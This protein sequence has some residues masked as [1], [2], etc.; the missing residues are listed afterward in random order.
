MVQCPRDAVKGKRSKISLQWSS[1]NWVPASQTRWSWCKGSPPWKEHFKNLFVPP[2]GSVCRVSAVIQ[3]DCTTSVCPI[4][5][6]EQEFSSPDHSA[7]VE[8]TFNSPRQRN[9]AEPLNI[10]FSHLPACNSSLK[11]VTPIHFT[12]LELLPR[13]QSVLFTLLTL[14]VSFH[15]PWKISRENGIKK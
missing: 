1:E 6:Y 5:M 3:D 7:L 14:Q 4:S 2:Q 13:Y 11:T 8:S 12:E 15:F 10:S 9:K